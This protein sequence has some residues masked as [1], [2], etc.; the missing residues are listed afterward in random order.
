[1]K[2]TFLVTGSDGHLGSTIVKQLL[3]KGCK[4]R[5]LRIK[6]SILQTPVIEEVY[7]GDVRDY[8]SMNDFFNCTNAVVIHT[9]GIVT[10]SKKMDQKI[11]DVNVKGCINV[12]EHAK[13]IKA[14]Y[15][16]ISSVHAINVEDYITA[17]HQDKY[18][19][20]V[21]SNFKKDVYSKTKAMATNLVRKAA[22]GTDKIDINIVYPA[23]I[24]GPGDYGNNH[25]NLVIKEYIKRNITT[26]IDGGY[27]LIDVRSAATAIVNLA[28]DD[29]LKNKEYLL[30][31]N[32]ISIKN[33]FDTLSDVINI[34]SPTIT[35]PMWLLKILNPA[36]SIFY[37]LKKMPSLYCNYSLKTLTK[38]IEFNNGEAIQDLGLNIFPIK[39]TII[40]TVDFYRKNNFLL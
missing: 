12:M 1:M 22:E 3:L 4:V 16:Y 23:G 14:R 30:T 25:L 32:Y 37:K 6:N 11:F 20:K 9:A 15:I 19:F 17:N 13:K 26:Y 5:G 34:K 10:I 31:G 21:E 18:P 27:N 36:T 38:K 40:D 29:K 8:K 24:L 35:L 7:Y 33:L 2:K 39:K 28:I